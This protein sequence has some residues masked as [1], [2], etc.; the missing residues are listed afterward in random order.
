M[1]L[2]RR[3]RAVG[4]FARVSLRA[5]FPAIDRSRLRFRGGWVA[6]PIFL[7]LNLIYPLSLE[8]AEWVFLSG[9]FTWLAIFGVLFGTL[10]GN[11]RMAVHSAHT[12]GAALGT[13][14]VVLLTIAAS[15]GGSF[16]ERGIALAT[17][18]NNWLT[19][20]LAGEA[21]ADQ[22]FFILFLGATV[23]TASFIGAFALARAH[24]AWEAI[25]LSGFCL[26][27]NVSLALVPLLFDLVVFSLCALVLLARL[28]IVSLQERW[29][30]RNI[31]PSG[32]MD[33]RL[34][35]GALTWTAVIVIMALATPRVS[36]AE[37]LSTAFTVFEGP[38]HAVEAEWQRFFAGV[39]GPSRLRGVSF[40]ESIRLGQ[41][42]NLGDRVVMMVETTGAGGRFWRAIAYD[43]YT[44]QGWRATETDRTDEVNPDFERRRE[45]FA[46]FEIIVPHSNLIFGANEPD[47]VS[48]PAQFLVGGDGS[49]SSG[50]RAVSRSQ[51]DD[52]YTVRSLVSDADKRT[53]R[54]AATTYPDHV[55]DKYLQLPSSLPERVRQLAR[56]VAAGYG[57]PYDQAEAIESYLRST[58]RYSTTVGTPPPGR[59]PVD[60]FLFDLKE[61]FCEYF[62]SSMVVMLR[63]LGVPARL[64]EGFTTGT[65]DVPSGKYV[66]RELNAHAWVEVYFPGYG[67]IEFEPT[68]SEVPF[69]RLD[70]LGPAPQFGEI[71]GTDDPLTGA[72]DIID[73]GDDDLGFGESGGVESPIGSGEAAPVDPRPGIAVLLLALVAMVAAFARFE[74]RFRGL[75]PVD[76]AW[77]KA[78]LLAAYV[79]HA[80]RP[81][82]TPYEYADSLGRAVPEVA[83]P[84]RVIA[85]ARVLER[86]T[87][88]GASAEDRSAAA[89]AWRRVARGLLMLLPARIARLLAKLLPA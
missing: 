1:A 7:V 42:P 87:L 85:R 74:L 41:A 59:D 26:T 89:R 31:Q 77:G 81:S 88:G 38:Y 22:T 49:Y 37:A 11:G 47:G 69:S 44:G 70:D 68:P 24:R 79:G 35:R 14:S 72:G 62:A 52:G 78:S 64:V 13:W 86:Y 61:D 60:Y 55:T 82:Q 33:W 39:S 63:E 57:N 30:R 54:D 10:V 84:L 17:S 53:L 9:H 76:A 83:E 43:F 67:W 20:V 28:H 16:R 58:Y 56:D 4:R 29:E 46:R 75:G 27:V 8:Q 23:W 48:I 3:L 5:L 66:V 73:R 71:D 80:Q 36:A 32:E 6:L 21:A 51:I 2:E 15:E 34:L 25:V 40:A 19:Q 12:F 18:L 50:V 65:F 45:F